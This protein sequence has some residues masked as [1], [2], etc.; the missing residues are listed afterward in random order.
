MAG[1]PGSLRRSLELEQ[2][3]IHAM[4]QQDAD[5]TLRELSQI[6]SVAAS[7]MCDVTQMLA[8]TSAG[9]DPAEVLRQGA[10]MP[11]RESK[12]MAK[13]AKQLSDMPKVKER[14]AAGRDHSPGTSM[15]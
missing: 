6:Q 15:L 10:R 13:I 12:R 8:S 1:I 9:T 2:A 7:L 11:T 3:R 14:F 5:E 4:S